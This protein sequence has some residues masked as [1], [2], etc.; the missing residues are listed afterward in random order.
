MRKLSSDMPGGLD[1]NELEARAQREVDRVLR[2]LPKPLAERA[3]LLPITFERQPN[4]A[5][6]ADGIEGG[7]GFGLNLNGFLVLPAGS[8]RSTSSAL[9]SISGI[10]LFEGA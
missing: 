8:G 3:R 1:W 2:S 4:A 6:V 5:L 9:R 7:A 10:G